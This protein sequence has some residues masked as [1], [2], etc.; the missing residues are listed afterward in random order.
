MELLIFGSLTDIIGKNSLV[1]EAPSNTEQLKKS[2][3]EQYPG[4]E[5][6]HYFLA[7]NKIMVHGN[8][9]LQEGDVVALM[10]AFSGG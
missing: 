4:L 9:L 1:L 2:L 5:Q 7:I 3:L 10:P 8:Q 6:A